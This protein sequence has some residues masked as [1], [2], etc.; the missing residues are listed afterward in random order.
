MGSKAPVSGGW[1]D[2]SA[3]STCVN[4]SQSRTRTCTNPS[5][6]CGGASCTGESTQT[7]GCGGGTCTDTTWLPDTS[8]VCTGTSFTQTSNCNRTRSSVGTKNCASTNPPKIGSCQ[9]FPG[10]NP[11]NADISNLPVHP[12]SANFINS[13]GS[14]GHLHADFGGGGAYG[15]PFIVTDNSTPL[16]PINFTAYGDE[17][18]PGPYPIP[19]TAPIE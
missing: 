16:I 17:S 14:S 11:W 3:W 1:S 15:I 6:S 18:D 5:P 13:I 2:W 19:L 9:I 12:N 7:Q 10:D 8:T 4:N